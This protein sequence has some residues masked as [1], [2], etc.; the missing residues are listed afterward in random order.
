MFAAVNGGA[1]LNGRR[2]PRVVEVEEADGDADGEPGNDRERQR[3]ERER[4]RAEEF[5]RQAEA[6]VI[7]FD[8]ADVHW[9]RGYCHLLSALLEVQLAHDASEWFDRCAHI[10][11]A[12][13]ETSFPFL[14]DGDR[15]YN[16]G[17]NFD[18]ADYIA[19]IHLLNFEVIEP[20][21][22]AAAREHLKAMVARSRDMWESALAESDVSA[23]WIP[24]PLQ[25]SVVGVRITP[26]MVD[27]WHDFLDEVDALLDGEK[28][29][30]F[31]RDRSRGVNLNRVF[32]DPRRFDLVMWIQG[33][34]AAPYVEDGSQIEAET[35]RRFQ[36]VFRGEFFGYAAWIN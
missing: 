1:R 23:E 9:L 33:T 26:E 31:W 29:I 3:R 30:P 25:N 35:W 36:R 22:M 5:R 27:T 6:L 15:T 21:R 17:G 12:K 28:L 2:A 24:N 34:G 10:F 7:D 4:V 8:T 19:A 11:F 16:I 13:P 20:E 14:R 18:P 32:T